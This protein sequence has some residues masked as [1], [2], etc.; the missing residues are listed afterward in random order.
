MIFMMTFLS[1]SLGLIFIEYLTVHYNGLPFFLTTNHYAWT[2][3]PTAVLTVVVGLWRKVNGC[4][5]VN[6]PWQELRNGPQPA[7]KTVLLDYMWPLQVVSFVKAV[8][9][10]HFAVASTILVFMLL[11]LIIVI[12]TTLFVPESSSFSQN[13]Q[14][15]LLAKFD[16][17]GFWNSTPA[18]TR[19]GGYLPSTD[20]YAPYWAYILGGYV[21]VTFPN[22]SADPVWTFS[23]RSKD[24]VST[25]FTSFSVDSEIPG[26]PVSVSAII[27]ISQ[28]NATCEPAIAYWSQ[29][30]P[31]V[32]INLTL[33]SP[34]CDIGPFKL[35]AYVAEP[36]SPTES[37]RAFKV[38][39]ANCTS[40]GLA[41]NVEVNTNTFHDVKYALIAIENHLQPREVSD[42]SDNSVH[43]SF[44]VQ[45]VAAVV[46]NMEYSIH[47]G[48]ASS[49]S[50]DL[51]NP[52]SLTIE[53]EIE[54]QLFNFT[55][56]EFSEVIIGSLQAASGISNNSDIA[57]DSNGGSAL[58]A[59]MTDSD[60]SIGSFDALFDVTALQVRAQEALAGVGQEVLRYY[61]LLPD[62]RDSQGSVEY[63]QQRL[64]VR[65]TA[66]WA[67]AG[68]FA[69]ASSLVVVVIIYT[70]Q[71]MAPPSPDTLATSAHVLLRSPALNDLLLDSGAMRS[72]EIRGHLKDYDFAATKDRA[73]IPRIEVTK[74]ARQV[75]KNKKI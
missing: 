29:D 15:N 57:A 74:V 22:V 19:M 56:L 53:E 38:I 65:P 43:N 52:N 55:N 23:H 46:C 34:S 51:F 62:N 75:Y 69:L 9:N 6:Q 21:G 5:M 11:K 63:L 50:S 64:H 18:P 27:D 49:S 8:K 68:L 73:G 35:N 25:A 37:G 54:H 10:K 36:T 4:A 30:I 26:T 60:P 44:Q 39:R 3:G 24:E 42:Q 72:S 31:G 32:S 14:I 7:D 70:H 47:R 20:T 58:L 13:V 16:A 66:L 28:V 40:G 33:L 59:L 45:R 71:E 61:F 17:Q 1:L 2:Y 48:K 12:S 41:N 67:M